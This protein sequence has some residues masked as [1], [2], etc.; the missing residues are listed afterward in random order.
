MGPQG[1]ARGGKGWVSE[2]VGGGGMDVGLGNEI[3][4]SIVVWV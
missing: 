1:V 2:W 4:S 3:G